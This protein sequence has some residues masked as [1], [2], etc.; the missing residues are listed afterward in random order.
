[1]VHLLQLNGITVSVTDNTPEEIQSF[2]PEAF[3]LMEKYIQDHHPK[4]WSDK[5][6]KETCTCTTMKK[7]YFEAK[8]N[9]VQ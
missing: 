4:N 3:N 6:Y 7:H 2:F 1:M 8:R 5:T 9:H